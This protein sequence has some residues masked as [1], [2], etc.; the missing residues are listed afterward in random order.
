MGTPAYMAPES[1]RDTTVD[2]R[3]DLFSLGVLAYELF[4]GELPFSGAT[5]VAL[6]RA[7]TTGLPKAPQQVDPALPA[8]IVGI[9]ARLLKKD[10]ADRYQTGAEVCA[11]LD[12]FLAGAPPPNCQPGTSGDSGPDWS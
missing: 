7:I 2:G 9:L 4:L 10:P 12:A 5:I 11:D 1:F 3:A 6:A 8:P